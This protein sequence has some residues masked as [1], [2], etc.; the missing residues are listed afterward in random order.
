MRLTKVELATLHKFD[1]HVA[2][3]FAKHAAAAVRDTL[4]RGA[5]DKKAREVTLKM[6][7]DPVV[8]RGDVTEADVHWKVSSKQPVYVTA[9]ARVLLHTPGD[10]SFSENSRGDPNQMTLMDGKDGD[11]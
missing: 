6:V 4:D 2:A 1:P 8:V 5:E 10:M 11:E 7:I 3:I 9:A